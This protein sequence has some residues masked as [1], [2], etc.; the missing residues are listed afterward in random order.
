[1]DYN[2]NKIRKIV[3]KLQDAINLTEISRALRYKYYWWNKQGVIINFPLVSLLPKE[4][5]NVFT[6]K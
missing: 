4:R 5:K 3:G 2:K 6:D 1:M